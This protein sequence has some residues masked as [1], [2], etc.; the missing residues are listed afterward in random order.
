MLYIIANSKTSYITGKHLSFL[1]WYKTKI[2][3]TLE[4]NKVK[5]NSFS[6]NTALRVIENIAVTLK[7]RAL[8]QISPGGRFALQRV[9]AQKLLR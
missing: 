8:E 7:G 3:I 2:Y 4:G 6:I 9:R 5:C 1:P